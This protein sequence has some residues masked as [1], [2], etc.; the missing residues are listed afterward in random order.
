MK[1]D[2]ELI[3]GRLLRRYKRFLADVELENGQIITAH[4]ANTGAMTGC[5][6]PGSQV[7][8][9]QSDN[10]KRKYPHTWE[11]VQVS[12]D[13]RKTLVGINTMRSN[14]LVVEAIS[15]GRVSTLQGY[16]SIRTEIK[17]GERSRV[18]LLLQAATRSCYV[19]VKN[20]TL[21]RDDCA[22]FP[23]AVSVRALKHVQELE[24]V[25]KLG[26]R[27]VLF[28]CVQ[29]SDVSQVRPADFI[30]PEY[31]R[32]L[33]QAARTGVELMAFKAIVTVEDIQLNEEIPVNI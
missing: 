19:E 22:F 11:L 6:E 29:R 16:D 17:Y 10:R 33:T 20:V 13:H 21:A 15:S 2:S 1:F 9:S 25:V 5:S 7:W 8:L 18:D 32:A 3:K 30:D 24:Q 4:T 28:Y 14:Q 23:D 12:N 31:S 26:G 27:A